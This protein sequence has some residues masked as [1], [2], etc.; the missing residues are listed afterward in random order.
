MKRFAA[1]V[2]DFGDTLFHSPS[3]VDE[4]VAAGVDRARA[5]RLWADVWTASKSAEAL[6]RGRDLD[7]DRHRA[8]WLDLL[9]LVEPDAPGLAPLLY[10]RVIH[11]DGWLPYPD[12]VGVLSALHGRGVLVGVL[13]N[14]PSGLRP[15]FERHGLASFVDAY[16]ESFHYGRVKPDPELFRIVCRELCVAPADALMVGD[17]HLADGAAVLAGVAALL[18]PPVTPGAERGLARVLDLCDASPDRLR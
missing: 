2:F 15:L 16:V 10:E 13:S 8:G 14:V 4:L 7:E 11:T 9:A 12:A 17:S 3:G 18:L 6:A 5:E 1:A